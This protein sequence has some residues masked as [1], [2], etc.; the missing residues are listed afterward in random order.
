M[1][2]LQRM[3]RRRTPQWAPI[4]GSNQVRNSVGGFAWAVDEWTRLRRFLILGSESGSYYAGEWALT[5]ENADA[6]ELCLA[7]DGAR[8]VQE[9][10][11]VSEGGRAPKNDPALYA[12]AMAAA[13][14]DLATRRAALGALPR[15]ARTST[16][17]FRFASFVEGL[18]GAARSAARSARGT[19]LARPSRSPT[20][21]SSTGVARA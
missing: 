11:A 3:S 9:I 1:T 16:H 20:W 18:A 2:Y 12:L 15:V 7:A 8:T 6:V 10:V 17:L 4:P 5:R 13:N 21:R 19:R 14:G